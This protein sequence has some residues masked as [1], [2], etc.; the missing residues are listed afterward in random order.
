[1]RSANPLARIAL[2]G[3]FPRELIWLLLSINLDP[4]GAGG[5]DA[6]LVAAFAPHEQG[7]WMVSVR[8]GAG[9]GRVDSGVLC[10]NP[11]VAAA[12]LL[13]RV[14]GL[15]EPFLVASEETYAILREAIRIAA[16]PSNIM[17]TGATGTGKRALAEVIQR[18]AWGRGAQ[19]RIDCAV[20]SEVELPVGA[21]N[22]PSIGAA[23]APFGFVV[24]DHFAELPRSHQQALAEVI[25]A[26]G[27]QTRYIAI[28][29]APLPRMREAEGFAPA[30]LDQFDATLALPALNRR[31]TDL[32]VLA[33]HFLRNA[34]PLLKLESS[35]L[36]ALRQYH[37]AGNV[38]ELQNM[39][40]RLEICEPDGAIRTI[41]QVRMAS[42]FATRPEGMN[43]QPGA[44]KA[45]LVKD[46]SGPQLRLIAS[47]TDHKSRS[48]R[49]G[50]RLQ[51]LKLVEDRS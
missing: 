30:L 38:R 6:D 5:F 25:Q 36:M 8:Q 18:A 35:A 15:A 45:Q 12:V 42:H 24:L 51:G 48:R 28:A 47:S 39:M 17:I 1:M 27:E 50:S 21:I 2:R 26:K 40:I 9:F 43:A 34:N 7:G 10:D 41:D 31:R 22:P 29:K 44:A 11:Y 33:H 23:S 16:G 20:S 49:H 3:D 32:E 4:F 14:I 13:S 19:H 46:P 37:F